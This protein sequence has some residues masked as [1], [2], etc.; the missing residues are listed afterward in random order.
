MNPDAPIVVD[1]R[2]I[3][4][5]VARLAKLYACTEEE[6]IGIAVKAE[7]VRSAKAAAGHDEV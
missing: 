4:A 3:L 7:L 1:D 2:A 6:V 5:S